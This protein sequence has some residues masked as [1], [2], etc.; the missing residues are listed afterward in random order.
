MYKSIKQMLEL[1]EQEQVKLSEIIIRNEEKHSGI[2]RK[3]IFEEM[4]KRYSVMRASSIKAL[5]T[6]MH[7]RGNLISGIAKKQNDY[8]LENKNSICGE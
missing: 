4:K 1:A 6:P 3:E 8:N 7:E 5:E 2:S